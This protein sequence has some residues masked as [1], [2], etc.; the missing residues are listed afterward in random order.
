MLINIVN[1]TE[2]I[3]MKEKNLYIC[4]VFDRNKDWKWKFQARFDVRSEN[5]A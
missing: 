3:L 2:I 1:A 5:V 4:E